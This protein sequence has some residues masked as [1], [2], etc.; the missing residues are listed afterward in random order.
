MTLPLITF[1][2]CLLI[3]FF[4]GAI[5]LEVVLLYLIKRQRRSAETAIAHAWMRH[6]GYAEFQIADVESARVDG[7]PITRD[8]HSALTIARV[9]HTALRSPNRPAVLDV[10]NRTQP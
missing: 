10:S 2:L 3:A 9:A 7:D 8:W 6:L 4:T 1:A 5:V